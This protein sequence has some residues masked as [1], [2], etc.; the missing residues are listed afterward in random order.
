M[1][2]NCLLDAQNTRCAQLSVQDSFPQCRLSDICP[3]QAVHTITSNDA[4]LLCEDFPLDRV[5]GVPGGRS[6][7]M[8]PSQ[9]V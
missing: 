5:L 6:N 8:I 3:I 1:L 4:G 7:T 9:R 2:V